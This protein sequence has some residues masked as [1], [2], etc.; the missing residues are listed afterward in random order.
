MAGLR[1]HRGETSVRLDQR[2]DAEPRTRPQDHL[3]ALRPEL[4]R[5]D[6]PFPNLRNRGQGQRL[7]LEIVEQQSLFQ[8]SAARSLGAVHHPGRIGELQRPPVHRPCPTGDHRAW[9]RPELGDGGLDRLRQPRIVASV[10]VDDVAKA[11]SRFVDERK[12]HIG[13]AGVADERG[14]GEREVGHWRP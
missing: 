12:A 6:T 1:R 10:Q 13:A 9:L 2:G 5:A 4:K 7:G 8:A 14:K 3:R 11:A